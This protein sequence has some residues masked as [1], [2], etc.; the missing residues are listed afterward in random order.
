MHIAL[1]D[2]GDTFLT[3]SIQKAHEKNPSGK[4]TFLHCKI[5]LNKAF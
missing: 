5:N 1:V 2:R 4:K 3:T